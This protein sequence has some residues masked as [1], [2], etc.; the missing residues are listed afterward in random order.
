[1]MSGKIGVALLATVAL[2]GCAAAAGWPQW[3]GPDRDGISREAGVLADWTQPPKKLW[4]VTTTGAGYNGPAVVG[5]ALYI[6]GSSGAGKARTGI[7][8]ARNAADGAILWQYEY[9]PEWGSSY[10]SARTTPTVADGRIYLVSGQGRV[11]CVNARDGQKVWAVDMFA[12]FNG[13]NIQWGIAESPLLVDKKVIC[14]PGGPDAAVA[15][16]DAATGETVWTTKGL[17]DASAYNSPALLVLNNRRQVVTQTAENVVGLDPE[18][19]AVLWKHPHKNKY[20]VHPNT[21]V[22]VAPDKVVV[23]SGYGYG[24]ECLQIGADGARRLWLV[25]EADCHFHGMLLLDKRLYLSSASTGA[26]FCI[27]PQTGNVLSK[28]DGVGRASIAATEAGILAYA[29]SGKVFLVKRSGDAC[30]ANGSF[31]VDFGKQ[32][33]WAQ[34]VLADG[35]LYVRHGDA[36]AAYDVKAK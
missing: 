24:T 5:N 17:G 6:A 27:D 12:R 33:H 15:A 36:L 26:L 2:A 22:A 21:P 4:Q 31:P 1:M 32:Q 8:E 9:G 20:A 18:T 30:Q 13:R 11:V 25:K 35:V 3:R 7:L 10:E 23:S 14:H 28:L 29:E 19:G 16:L 34:P